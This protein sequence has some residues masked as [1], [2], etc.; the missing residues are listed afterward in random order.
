MNLLYLD[1]SHKFPFNNLI[2]EK[3]ALVV[4]SPC[5]LHEIS[6]DDELKGSSNYI[7]TLCK[8]SKEFCCTFLAGT[9]IFCKD[10]NFWGTI[11]VDH[12]K[13]VGISDMT[14]T[15]HSKYDRSSALTVFDT[16]LGRMGVVSGEDLFFPE[17]SRV[18][19]LWECDFLVFST[20]LPTNRKT[21]L[22]AES[23][24]FSNGVCGILVGTKSVQIF[25]ARSVHKHSPNRF[26]FTHTQNTTLIKNRRSDLYY[27][28]IK[29][30]SF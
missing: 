21:K 3:N 11:I 29:R 20:F 16:T 23:H 27:E 9:S 10:K 5:V 1:N 28:V 6:L 12:G 24:A 13:F 15:V 30:K 25:N 19:R 18:L 26:S 7:K 8:I 4:L 14:H 22:L 2:L 17:V